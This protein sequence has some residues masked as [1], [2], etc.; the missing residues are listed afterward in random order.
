MKKRMLMII[1]FFCPFVVFA[2]ESFAEKYLNDYIRENY[3]GFVLYAD[4]VLTDARANG[5]EKISYLLNIY[6]IVY[7]RIQKNIV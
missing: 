6:A 5:T 2:E 4:M 3:H 1:L 7:L